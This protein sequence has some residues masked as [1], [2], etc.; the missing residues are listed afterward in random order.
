ML[1]P[2][3]ATLEDLERV[4]VAESKRTGVELGG[5]LDLVSNMKRTLAKHS[6]TIIT[7]PNGNLKL[8]KIAEVKK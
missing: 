3:G 8:V 5:C 2:N 4:R 1:K 6:V 7:M